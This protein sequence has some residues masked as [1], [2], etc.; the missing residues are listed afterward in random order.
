MEPSEL[1]T[2]NPPVAEKTIPAPK[3]PSAG[4]SYTLGAAIRAA[5]PELKNAS[6]ATVAGFSDEAAPLL[7]SAGYNIVG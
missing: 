6:H 3:P 5:W 7:A 1:E 4:Q 2:R